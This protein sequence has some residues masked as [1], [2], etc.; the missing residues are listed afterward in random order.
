V[1]VGLDEAGFKVP[2]KKCAVVASCKNQVSSLVVNGT[3]DIVVV[4]V[5]GFVGLSVVLYNDFICVI[6]IVIPD[7]KFAVPSDGHEVR[8]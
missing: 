3:H 7:V 5:L 1:H 2:A 4:A 6:A 8:N